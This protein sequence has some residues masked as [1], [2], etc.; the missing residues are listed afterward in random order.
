MYSSTISKQASHNSTR[1]SFCWPHS[2]TTLEVVEISHLL[3]GLK[4]EIWDI[5]G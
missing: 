5:L 2:M 1:I 4:K 3:D